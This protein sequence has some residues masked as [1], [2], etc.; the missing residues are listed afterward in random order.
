[1]S[2]EKEFN[3]DDDNGIFENQEGLKE[4]LISE[5]DSIRGGLTVVNMFLGE[6]LKAMTEFLNVIDSKS[7]KSI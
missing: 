4:I 1:M 2:N 6:P 7:K 5:I 3:L